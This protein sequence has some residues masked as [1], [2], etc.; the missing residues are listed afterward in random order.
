MERNNE[1]LGRITS[2]NSRLNTEIMERE[3]KASAK[4][5]QEIECLHSKI[6][7]LLEER[8]LDEGR[9]KDNV[10]NLQRQLEQMKMKHTK[11]MEEKL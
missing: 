1:E 4:Q 8:T 9:Y 3:R 5:K 11:I 10:A 7:A 2:E 6:N